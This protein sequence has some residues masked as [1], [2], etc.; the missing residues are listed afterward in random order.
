M[1][2]DADSVD[3]KLCAMTRI[4][5]FASQ[6]FWADNCCWRRAISARSSFITTFLSCTIFFS[7]MN[8]CV[9]CTCRKN[10]LKK[11]NKHLGSGNKVEEKNNTNNKKNVL[12][13]NDSTQNNDNTE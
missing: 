4:Q 9:S 10:R 12:K 5:H 1:G 11:V 7:A 13:N 2:E 6:G 3:N 8:W